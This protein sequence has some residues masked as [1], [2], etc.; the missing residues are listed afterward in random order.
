MR[1]YRS[2]R[3]Y[4]WPHRVCCF[5]GCRS[6]AAFR[7]DHCRWHRPLARRVVENGVWA[8]GWNHGLDSAKAALEHFHKGSCR[9]YY[10]E[11][12]CTCG[13]HVAIEEKRKE[14]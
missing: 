14:H 10:A 11:R 3:G 2:T 13:L 4:R 7:S 9:W 8:S 1:R 6:R 12:H 5:G